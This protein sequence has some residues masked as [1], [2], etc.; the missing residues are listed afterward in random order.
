MGCEKWDN[1]LKPKAQNPKQHFKDKNLFW[2][3]CCRSLEY[4]KDTEAVRRLTKAAMFQAT[5]VKKKI[6]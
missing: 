3:S 2:F 5:P 1:N 4:H 6:F